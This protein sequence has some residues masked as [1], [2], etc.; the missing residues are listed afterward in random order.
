MKRSFFG[1]RPVLYRY[2]L[3]LKKHFCTCYKLFRASIPHTSLKTPLG[4]PSSFLHQV[5]FLILIFMPLYSLKLAYVSA[6]NSHKPPGMLW[7]HKASPCSLLL[8]SWFL[9]LSVPISMPLF[10]AQHLSSSVNLKWFHSTP[11]L[12]YSYTTNFSYYVSPAGEWKLTLP[13]HGWPAG[14]QLS[15]VL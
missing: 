12:R 9:L 15:E 5:K 1:P 3:A 11:S 13:V 7:R 10:S 2:N 4:A 6:I 14:E 8:E